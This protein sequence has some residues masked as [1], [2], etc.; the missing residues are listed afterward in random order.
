MYVVRGV[1]E[2][3]V[4]VWVWVS[5]KVARQGTA[6]GRGVQEVELNKQEEGGVR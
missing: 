6:Y 1:R 5:P 3:G 2:G 4:G